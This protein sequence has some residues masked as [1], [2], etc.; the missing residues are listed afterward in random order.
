[1][2]QTGRLTLP[3]D[4]DVVE[5]TLR[6]KA[7]LGA[8]ALRDCDGTPELILMATGSEV[9]ITLEAAEALTAEGRKVRVVSMPCCERF[10]AQDAA[11]RESVLPS[12]VRARVAVEAAAADYW[13][14]Y[15]GLD[16]AVLGMTTFGASGPGKALAEHFGFTAAHLADMARQLLG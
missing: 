10:D 15:V 14:K 5:E 1:M 11:Y 9:G 2:E 7:L 13:R 4:A 12:A 8:D 6:L 16:G 3:T